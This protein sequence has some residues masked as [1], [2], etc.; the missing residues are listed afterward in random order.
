MRGMLVKDFRL[1]WM[2]KQFFAV[3]IAL[4]VFL[5]FS[6]QTA[7]FIIF[8]CMAMGMY[9]SLSMIAYDEY[10]NGYAFLFTLPVSRRGYVI[11]KYVF[12]VICTVA[13]CG[14][15]ATVCGIAEWIRQP[16]LNVAELILTA[17][18]GMFAMQG[19][20]AVIVPFRLKFGA[21]KGR[22]VIVIA[23]VAISGIVMVTAQMGK[24]VPALRETLQQL[25]N[26]SGPALCAS[27]IL[28]VLAVMGISV[29]VS[30]HI[31]EKKQ[32]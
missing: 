8:Y 22:I 7:S 1:L 9:L 29:P 19:L 27:M 15:S 10:E 11:E 4:S 14:L 16:E 20:F 31:V 2:Q 3:I 23:T 26:V 5:L 12:S 13:M 30:I 21:E 18:S 17:V 32:F 25:G 28:A 6:G 24:T